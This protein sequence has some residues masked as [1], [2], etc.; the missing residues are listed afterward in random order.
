MTKKKAGK[1]HALMIYQRFIS[2]IWPVI[3]MLGCILLGLW[4]V[5]F[6][7][8]VEVLAAGDETWLAYAA[9][10]CL[11]F[12][13]LI[14]IS[15]RH[16]YVQTRYNHIRLVLPFFLLRVSYRRVVR[17]N[18][19]AFNVL[20]PPSQANWAQRR[21]LEPFYGRTVLVVE[22][23]GYPMP[24]HILH[25]FLPRYIF[26]SQPGRLILVVEDWM[27]LSMEIDSYLGA[28]RQAQA[29]RE[30]AKKRAHMLNK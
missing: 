11:L 10:V 15:R 16:A 7:A 21:F 3:F 2:R 4:V 14:L 18:V 30:Y 22:L 9:I 1:R 23:K 29:Q 26:A 5:S 17:S 13:L 28:W 27:G 20:F 24:R 12:T 19:T 8:D 6:F 25:L